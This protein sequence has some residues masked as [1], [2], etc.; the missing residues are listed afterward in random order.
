MR[1]TDRARRR[2]L[3]PNAF[4]GRPAAGRPEVLAG[5]EA[6]PLDRRWS[7]VSRYSRRARV[8]D[9]AR[10][11][12]TGT[13]LLRLEVADDAPFAFEPG[14]FVGIEACVEGLGYK[15]S[16]YCIVSAPDGSRRF[17]LLVRVV[18]DGPVSG[19]LA[20]LVPGAEV[21]FRGPTGRSMVPKDLDRDLVLVGTGVAVGPLRALACHLLAT[22]FERRIELFWGLRSEDDLC[23]TDSLDDLARH[24]NFDWHVSLSQASAAWDGLRGRVTESVPPLL[25]RLGGRHF[26]LCGNGSMIEELS[27]A[28]SDMGVA[29]QH[30]YAEPYFGGRERPDPEV[31][32][33]IRQRFAAA[34]L[35]SAFAHQASTLF[36]LER[37][38]GNADPSAPSDVFTGPDFLAHAR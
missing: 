8:L 19:W 27:A 32:A 14:N 28:L 33:A 22:G 21:A 15:R 13:L 7:A 37:P 29:Q 35:F 38:L 16:P 20:G 31:V 36:A 5:A 23:L 18:P 30:V 26:V 12:S 1:F 34:D 3:S 10:L 2:A 4:P 17:E 11:T 25:D 9:E 6:E 24:P